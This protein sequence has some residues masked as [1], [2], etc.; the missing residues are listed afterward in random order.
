M[1][2]TIEISQ[3]EIEVTFN[4]WVP[5]GITVQ[6]GIIF[7]TELGEYISLIMLHA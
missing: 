4:N 5:K 2:P 7:A 3:R 6:I 1:P